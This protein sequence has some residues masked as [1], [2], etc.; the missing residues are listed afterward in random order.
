MKELLR[1]IVA[2]EPVAVQAV[3]RAVFV[4]AA[5]IGLGV[6]AEVQGRVL[7]VIAALYA[8][9]EAVTTLWARSRVSPVDRVQG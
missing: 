1:R 6:S 2:L 4:L 3:A 8:L 5:A 9:I 7:A